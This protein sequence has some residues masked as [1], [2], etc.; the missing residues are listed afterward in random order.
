MTDREKLLEL[1]ASFNI[2][3]VDPVDAGYGK[4]DAVV[5]QAHH[6]NVEGYYDFMAVFTFDEHGNFLK[7]GIWE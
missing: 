4:T 3:P 2:T 1:L 6:G 5:L 7:A